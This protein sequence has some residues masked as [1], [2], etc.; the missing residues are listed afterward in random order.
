[1]TL[2]VYNTMTRRKEPFETIEPGVVRMYVCG[3][4][5]YSDAH[6]GHGLMAVTFDVI[7]RYLE[8]QGYT[9]YHAQNYTDI[10]DKIIARAAQEGIEPLDLANGL[11]ES[12]GA[13]IAALNV[14]PATY[15]PRAT[16][17][18]QHMIE[19]VEGLV[20]RNYAYEMEGDVNYD[21]THFDEYGKLS[22]RKLDDMLAGARVEVDERKHHPMDFALWKAAKPGEPFWESPWGMGR[23]GWHI[24]CSV[25]A[26]RYLGDRIDIHGGGADLI[27]PH[28]ENEIAQSEAFPESRP[29]ARYWV[30][31][32]L[33]QLGGEKMSKSIGNLVTI[34]ELLDAGHAEAFRFYVL[35]THYRHPLTYTEEGLESAGRGYERLK[36]ALR[37]QTELD[38]QASEATIAALAQASEQFQAAMDDDFNTPVA[39]AVLFDL[40]RLA[41]QS[42]GADRAAAQHALV[43]LGGILGLPLGRGSNERGAGDAGPFIELLLELREDLRAK[44]EWE[45]ADSVRDRLTAM[46]VTVEDSASGSTWRWQ[47]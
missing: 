44:R 3:T 33:L 31:N 21:V 2:S 17:E 27:F 20:E 15:Y 16:E 6:I 8:W 40:A 26:R 12:F 42:E 22:H 36:A 11:I 32:A 37:N 23:P 46:G 14:L 19:M 9:V 34:R 24:E 18:V 41:N 7:R 45:L 29:F 38:G 25:M 47:R 30:H 13:E 4:T 1:M 39:V 5:P 43:E 10:D 28:H 35:Q